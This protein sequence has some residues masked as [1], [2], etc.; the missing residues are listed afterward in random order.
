ML[1]QV[2]SVNPSFGQVT[3]IKIP[4]KA[5]KVTCNGPKELAEQVTKAFNRVAP[6]L[7]IDVFIERHSLPDYYCPNI[8]NVPM[9]LKDNDINI[10]VVT[11]KEHEAFK[12]KSDDDFAQEI[13]D[14]F[15]Q[16]Y[17]ITDD[18]KNIES[19]FDDGEEITVH[20]AMGKI[21]TS[22]LRKLFNLEGKEVPVIKINSLD[23]ITSE[24]AEKI[25]DK[26]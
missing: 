24:L 7:G 13:A 6:D 1:S 11:G 2:N 26:E 9:I 15:K 5:A 16:K 17:R 18:I 12:K 23:D 20:E 10:C 21:V 4:R 19:V 25:K 8:T 3:C 22:K 14:E